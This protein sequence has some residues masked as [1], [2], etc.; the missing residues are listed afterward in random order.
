MVTLF[1]HGKRDESRGR[2]ASDPNPAPVTA[3]RVA[4]LHLGYSHDQV[5]LGSFALHILGNVTKGWVQMNSSIPQW[6]QKSFTFLQ[7]IIV[8]HFDFSSISKCHRPVSIKRIG[9]STSCGSSWQVGAMALIVSLSV[10]GCSKGLDLKPDFSSVEKYKAKINLDLKDIG[11]SKTEAFNWAV[12]GN[13]V[14]DL[15][16]KYKDKTYR[17]IAEFE[18]DRK[19]GIAKIEAPKSQALIKKVL[20]ELKKVTVESS[21]PR[22]KGDFFGPQFFFDLKVSNQSSFDFSKLSWIAKLYLDGSS[23][24]SAEANI[25]SLYESKGGLKAGQSDQESI[26]VGSFNPPE[27]WVTLA[28]QNA[29]ERKV[30]IELGN[31]YNFSNKSYLDDELIEREKLLEQIPSIVEKYKAALLK[32]EEPPKASTTVSTT[33]QVNRTS[34]TNNCV[35]GSCTRTFPDGTHE[36]W[37]AQRKFD[38]MSQNWEWDTTTNAC[39]Q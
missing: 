2:K 39:G 38:P 19:L 24:A 10:A 14:E 9:N 35:N 5:F 28:S 25:F 22:I 30:V 26:Q 31:A 7:E 23:T 12:D 36:Q 16:K 33:N 15:Q 18:M 34:C 4:G 17:Q 27:G 3:G 32:P 21:N 37:Q 11:E 13:N 20:E 29:K 6:L 1:P 8:R